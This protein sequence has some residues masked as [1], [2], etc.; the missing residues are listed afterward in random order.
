MFWLPFILILIFGAIMSYV[1]EKGWPGISLIVVLLHTF[2]V[3][4]AFSE[5][6]LFWIILLL[7]IQLWVVFIVTY[8]QRD[9]WRNIERMNKKIFFSKR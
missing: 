6:P 7:T 3:R 2:I 4:I 8:F 1:G 9:R 5:H